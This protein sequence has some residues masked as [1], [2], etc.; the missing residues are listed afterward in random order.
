MDSTTGPRRIRRLTAVAAAVLALMLMVAGCSP[1]YSSERDGK[2]L[3]Q[4]VCDLRESED[5]DERQAAIDDIN[6]ELENLEQEYAF[7][8]SDDSDAFQDAIDTFRSDAEAGDVQAM[9]QDL[10]S[11]DERAQNTAQNAGDVTK[12]A[13][14]GLRQGLSDCIG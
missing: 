6:S 11:L 5:A 1:K 8:T 10:A 4:A 7:Y 12:A 13:W 2:A 14:D 9:Q 3:G